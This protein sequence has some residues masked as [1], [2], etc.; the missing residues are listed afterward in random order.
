MPLFLSQ[1]GLTLLAEIS[2]LLAGLNE[3]RSRVRFPQ[4]LA[5]SRSLWY[6]IEGSVGIIRSPNMGLK[7]L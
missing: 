5:R 1:S 3:P 4:T 2:V 7:L 6:I